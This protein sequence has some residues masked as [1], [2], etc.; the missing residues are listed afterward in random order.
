MNRTA[1]VIDQL[2]R[3]H[4]SRPLVMDSNVL[5][6]WVMGHYDRTSIARFKRT[7]QYSPDD[8]DLLDRMTRL[9]KQ[10][11]TTA[12]ILA[13]VNSLCGQVGEGAL[14]RVRDAFAARVLVMDERFVQA[15]DLVTLTTFQRYGL[16]DTA[17]ATVAREGLLVLTDDYR[18][19]GH[20]A[21]HELS[22]VN[23]NHVRQLS[24]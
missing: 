14:T 13:E 16:S 24:W 9:F 22:V 7:A 10:V 5:L 2:I 15:R 19:A 4:R 8:F 17:V 6:L 3:R 23:F 21:A 11:A 1:G 20:L 18:L 12:H